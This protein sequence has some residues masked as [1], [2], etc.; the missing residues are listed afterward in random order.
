MKLEFKELLHIDI[1]YPEFSP[2]YKYIN[3]FYRTFAEKYYDYA[4]NKH[5]PAAVKRYESSDDPRKRFKHKAES[6]TM[7]FTVTLMNDEF[8][9]VDIDI[10]NRRLSQTWHGDVILP[11][12]RS[13][14]IT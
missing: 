14:K 2:A 6:V 10:G 12:K 11:P 7:N 8:I 5:Y 9:S 4:V 3:D 1:R 13:K